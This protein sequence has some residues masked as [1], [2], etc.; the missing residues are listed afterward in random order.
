MKVPLFLYYMEKEV[1]LSEIKDLLNSEKFDFF[2][3]E[4]QIISDVFYKNGVEIKLCFN[5]FKLI[6]QTRELLYKYNLHLIYEPF[7]SSNKEEISWQSFKI[8]DGV[9]IKLEVFYNR[10]YSLIRIEDN[11]SALF[12]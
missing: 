9:Q 12:Y 2:E 8:T 3:E 4:L 5:F 10:N 7:I 6:L 11:I 1:Y